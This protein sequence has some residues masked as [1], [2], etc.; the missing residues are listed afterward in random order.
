MARA[1]QAQSTQEL[2]QSLRE[3]ER[4]VRD[5]VNERPLTA[6]TAAFAAGYV[7]GGGLTPRLTWLALTAA[8]RMT[9]LNMFNDVALNRSGSRRPAAVDSQGGGRSRNSRPQ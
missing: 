6:V 5:Y 4:T 3:F 1:I 8:G 2:E 9:L 7:L